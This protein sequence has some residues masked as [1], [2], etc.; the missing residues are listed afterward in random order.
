MKY[1]GVR[2]VCVCVNN[3]TKYTNN[4]HR[5]PDERDDSNGSQE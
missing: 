5:K 2:I 4:V 1:T 3:N